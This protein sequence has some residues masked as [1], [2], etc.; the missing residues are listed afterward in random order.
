MTVERPRTRSQRAD[1]K[2]IEHNDSKA[3]NKVKNAKQKDCKIAPKSRPKRGPVVVEQKKNEKAKTSTTNKSDEQEKNL[4]KS[5]RCV[6]AEATSKANIN[7]KSNPATKTTKVVA[8]VVDDVREQLETLPKK[9]LRT[10]KKMMSNHDEIISSISHSK[11]VSDAK[12]KITL[13]KN[14]GKVT[15]RSMNPRKIAEEA[16]VMPLTVSSTS[17]ASSDIISLTDKKQLKLASDQ[18]EI[19]SE[20]PYDFEISQSENVGKKVKKCKPRAVKINSKPGNKI[21][22]LIQQQ[23]LEAVGHSCSMQ[24]NPAI[25]ETERK[26][27]KKQIN[28]PAS[29][30]KVNVLD[31][32][33]SKNENP[34]VHVQA[35]AHTYHSK[36]WHSPQTHS[37]PQLDVTDQQATSNQT[38]SPPIK[39]K[40]A[41]KMSEIARCSTLTLSSPLRV[42]AS[43]LPS[44]FYMELSKND[45]TP[46]F[47]SDLLE[48][49]KAQTNSS[50]PSVHCS[51]KETCRSPSI[52][53]DSNAENTTPVG[54]VKLLSRKSRQAII[55]TPLKSL[56]IGSNAILTT[57]DSKLTENFQESHEFG[58]ESQNVSKP[59]DSI[60]AGDLFGFDELLEKDRALESHFT[61]AKEDIRTHLNVIRKYLPS[62]NFKNRDNHVFPTAMKQVK[63][64]E[65][66]TNPSTMKN[67]LSSS[68]PIVSASKQRTSRF[69]DCSA[70]ADTIDEENDY[71]KK[72]VLFG[73]NSEIQNVSI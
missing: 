33:S 35:V 15:L 44:A 38:L 39:S 8:P 3:E 19:N 72:V 36:V 7:K 64:L 57:N 54:F 28:I 41:M 52:L 51:S 68:T 17:K 40:Y 62:K 14:T 21:E 4:R 66:P 1:A 16:A 45:G 61:N 9:G 49:Q 22:L 20:D 31:K 46:S 11:S 53:D 73:E 43:A 50:L 42:S 65:T 18:L 60:T 10:G 23:K 12:K 55:R 58:Q 29:I 70:I 67:F 48:K 6:K 71:R 59:Y 2:E 27:L 34:V 26:M 47:S 69:E 25:Y 56:S 13:P 37:E 32:Q 24:N 5:Q 30:N 63:I